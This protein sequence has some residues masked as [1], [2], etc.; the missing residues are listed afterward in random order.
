MWAWIVIAVA[1]VLAVGA[2]WMAFRH[3]RSRKLRDRFGPEYDRAVDERG[4]RWKA[5]SELAGRQRRREELEIRTLDPAARER[6]MNEWQATQSRFV[7]DPAEAV[8]QADRLVTQ[9]M[10]DRGYPMEDFEQRSVDISV[11]HAHVVDDYR[12]AHAISMANEHG[13]AGTEDLRQAMVHYR[14]LFE[15]L[16]EPRQEDRAAG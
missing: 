5:E 8:T 1:L 12:A 14:R 15:D 11:D 10:R 9:V 2:A 3:R 16:L 13:R 7:D 6:Y 4:G